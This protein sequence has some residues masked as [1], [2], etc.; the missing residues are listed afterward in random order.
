M[1]DLSKICD[2][3]K[4]QLFEQLEDVNAGML[5]IQGSDLHMQPM[6]HQLDK[7]SER[8]VF[9]TTR[10]AE[11]T[12]ALNGTEKAH[13]TIVSKDQ[14]YHACM[15]GNLREDRLEELIEKHW[16]P[17]VEAWFDGKDDPDMTVLVFTPE[18]A[19][20]WA[21][22][23]SAIRFGWEILRG[24]MGDHDPD[25]GVTTEIEFMAGKANTIAAE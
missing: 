9:F 10:D 14:D 24:K 7:A 11:L 17:V 20:L 22:T 15:Q 19:K 25:L 21:S 18:N 6:A 12:K 8:I 5:G 3:P 1:A 16:S 2:D 4:H 23:D 13:F